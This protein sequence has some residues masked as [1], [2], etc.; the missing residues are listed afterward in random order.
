V[1]LKRLEDALAEG[2][3]V[4]AVVRGSAVNNDG[5]RKVGYTAPGLDG[6]AQVIAEA[7]AHAGVDAESIGYIEA[8]GTATPL[9]DAVELAAMAQA[10][11]RSTQ[12][13]QFCAL[14][15]VKP[16]VGHLDRAAGVAGLIKTALALWH[17]Q[18]PP[19]LNFER[20]SA[21]VE[22]ENSPFYVNTRLRDWDAG[23]GPR[24]AGV[25]SFGLGGTNAHVVL[26]EAPE[27]APSDPARGAQ[28]LVLSAKTAT[29]LESMGR[30]LARHLRAHGEL[31]VADVAYT[32]QVG[33]SAFNH[34]RMLVCADL[35]DAIAGLEQGRGVTVE[36]TSRDRA[37][38]LRFAAEARGGLGAE[39]I[40]AELS[41]GAALAAGLSG[42]HA[43]ARWLVE[44]GVLVAALDGAGV[45]ARMRQD[46]AL[47]RSEPALWIEVSA[48]ELTAAG[49]MEVVG[50]LWLGGVTVG[51]EELWKGARRRRVVLPT[52]PFERRRY[53][54]EAAPSVAAAEVAPAAA[55]SGRKAE[56][57]DWFYVPD[58]SPVSASPVAGAGGAAAGSWIVVE[59]AGGTGAGVAAHLAAAGHRVRRI[60][61]GEA[62]DIGALAAGGEL[63]SGIVHLRSLDA[64]EIAGGAD[65]FER[66]RELGFADV[67]ALAADLSR[68]VAD[69]RIDFV[70]ASRAVQAVLPGEAGDAE[71]APLIGLCK[72]I[73]Q[74]NVTVTCRSVD[75]VSVGAAAAAEIAQECLGAGRDAVVS[76]RGGQRYVQAYAPRRLAAP[77]G[78]V[79]RERGVYLITGGL[80]G[81]GLVLAEHMARQVRA[82]LVLLGRTAPGAAQRAK[83]S[84]LE[85]LGA[86][87]LVVTADV[88]DAA[89]VAAAVAQAQARFGGLDGVVHAAG[90]TRGEGF[91][92]L[93]DVS[94]AQCDLHFGPK[95]LGLYSLEQALADA[96]LDFC[97]VFS[98][99]ASVLGGLGFAA[100]AAANSFMDAFVQRHNRLEGRA[101]WTSVNWDTWRLSASDGDGLG[102]TVAQ[103]EMRPEEGIAAFERV[104]GCGETQIVNSTGDLD[105]RIRQ[106]VALESV[107]SGE[108]AAVAS[109]SEGLDYA[110]RIAGVW[111][112]V[113]GV[114]QVGLHDNFF[115]LGGNS[116][117]GLQ[118]IARLKKEFKRQIPAVALFE[119][120]TVSALAGYLRPEGERGEDREIG[121]LAQR[122]RQAAG[123]GGE[124][125]II[126]MV[127]RFPGADDVEELWGNLR[128]GVESLTRFSDEELLASGIDAGLIQDPH[129][130]KARPILRDVE[131][132][133][134]GLFGY[135]PR[136]AEL[137][138]PQQRLFQECAWEVL[139]KAGY[140]PQRYAGLIGVFG[141]TNL[142]TYLLRLAGDPQVQDLISETTVLEND[143]D[144]LTLNVSYRL[145]LRGPSVAVQTFCSTSLVAVHMACRA[146]RAGDC[147]L[148]LA[149]GVSVRV[150]VKAGYLYQEG[151]Q[152]SHDGHCRTFDSAADGTMFGDGVALVVLKRLRE[153]IE[154]GD[155]VH[156]VIKGSAVNNDG[157]LK[158]GY[159]APSVVGQAA[160]VEAALA[161]AGVT[162][163]SI[164][165]VEAHGTATRLGDP[166][167]V[168]ALSKAFR[169]TTQKRNYCALGSIKPNV[170]HLDRAAGVSG[171]IKTVLSL[172]H[173]ELP[174]TLHFAHPNPEI[175]FAAS[176][177]FVVRERRAWRAGS[178]PRRACVNSLGVGGT[179]A[180]VV[181]EEAPARGPSG[182]SRGWHLLVL[183]GRSAAALERVSERLRAHLEKTPELSLA[184]AAHTLQVGRRVLEHRRML[185]C[186]D[187][188]EAVELLGGGQARR[189]WTRAQKPANRSVAM[190]FA[191]VGEQYAGCGRELYE[192]EAC[193]RSAV[194]RCCRVLQ[195]HLGRDLREVMLA[196]GSGAGGGLGALIGRGV[197]VEAPL[198]ETALSQPAAFVLDYA[199]AQLW[200]SW[201]VQPAAVLGYSV[202]EYVAACV[203]GVFS[204]EDALALVARRAQAIDKLAG[205]AMLAVSLDEAQVQGWVDRDIAL[206]AVNSP[207]ACV[208]AG[209]AEAI[210]RLQRRLEAADVACH[211]VETT[212]A[213]HTPLL[214]PAAAELTALAATLARQAP[215]IPCLSNVTGDWMT[216]AQAGDP[217]YWAEHMCQPVRFADAVDKLLQQ[218]NQLLLEVGPAASLA[219]F[220]RQHPGCSRERMTEI[221]ST[222]APPHE[223]Q[224]ELQAML[225][226]LGK[227]WLLDLKPDWN[228]F[229]QDQKR[230]KIQLPTY[231]FERQHFW[232]KQKP[233]EAKSAIAPPRPEGRKPDP[234]DWFYRPVWQPSVAPPSNAAMQPG[235]FV[236][237]ADAGSFGDWI[238]ERLEARARVFR[239]RSG[240]AFERTDERSFQ[241]R[242]GERS[243]YAQLVRLLAAAQQ[244]MPSCIHL[245]SVDETNRSFAE[246]QERAV[247]S[248]LW[249][250][251]ALGEHN[252]DSTS[253]V[254]IVT[255][256]AQP[257]DGESLNVSAAPIVAACTVLRQEY[258]GLRC[259][260]VDICMREPGGGG[261]LVDTLADELLRD[262]NE[263]HIAFRG[264]ARLAPRFD[265]LRLEAPDQDI[266]ARLRRHGVYLILGGLGGIGLN[267]AK[268]LAR[269]VQ[270]RLI[271]VSRSGR[272]VIPQIL[273]E[274]ESLGAE[275]LVHRADIAELEQLQQ[276]VNAA[277][278][279][280]GAIDGV[281]HAAGNVNS[282][283]FI[284]VQ[285]MDR[286]HC[287]V[288]FGAKVY[289]LYNLETVLGERPLDFCLLFS[290]ISSVLGGIGYLGYTAA[291]SFMDAF[292]QRHNRLGGRA[293][294][295]SVNWDT[296]R[297]SASD[298]DGLGATVAQYEMR[299]EEGIAAFERVL[300][301]GETQIVNSTGDLDA[302]IRQWV[303]LESVRS[304]EQ[305]AVASGSEGLDYAER[306]AGVWRHVLGV[307][308]VGLHDNFFDLGGN[309]LIGLQLIARLKKEF[310]RQIP[311]VALFE[312]PTVSALAGY[313]RPEGE[314][315]EDREIGRLAQ[316]RRQAAGT[317]GEIAIIAMV[318]RF[319]GADDVEELWGNL[320]DGVESLT[321]FSDEELLASGI[322]AGLIQDPHYVKARPILRDVEH[323]D[324]GLFGYTPREAELMDPQQRLFQ[325]CAWEVLEK[326]GYDPQRY[327]GLI[328]V[329]G[330]TNLN[331]YLLRLAGDP[332][333]QDLISETTV[334]EN[335]KDALTLNVSYRLNLRGPSV[336]VQTFCSTSLVAVHM[337]CRALRAGDCD[338]ALAGGVSV[339]VP[340]KA[341]YL[342]QEGDQVSH[343]GHC[344][345]FDSAADGTMFG[346]GV[347]LVVLKR[348]REAIEDGDE[349][350][351][352][353]KG[354][355][356]NNDGGLKVGYTAPSVV[357]QAAVVEAALADA[358]VTAES[359]DYVEAHGTAT[360]LGDPIEV[361]ALSKA[362]RSTTQKRNYCALGSIKPNVGH[363]DRA[364]GVSGLIKTVLSL[365]HEELPATLHFAHPNPE[366]DFAASPFFV[367]RERRAWRAG[368]RPRRACVNSLGVGG[369]NAHVVVEEAP[370]RGPSGPSRGWHLLVLSGRSAAALERVSERLRAH[371]EKTPELSLADAA[372][373]LQVGRRVL[374][375]RRMLVCRDVGE[376]VELLGGGQAR[377]VWT[378]AQKPANRSVAMVFAG[379]GEQYAGCGRELYESE[380]CFRSAVDRCCR[381]LQQ[382]LGRD[383]REVM[384][385]P[386]SGA[387]GGLGA[388]IGRGVRVEAPL[389]E[390]ALSQPAA[391]VLDYA[392]AQ[393]WMSWGVQPAA[394]LGYSVGE[395]VAACVA[396]VF[397]LED[398]LALVA[399]RAQA[400]DKLAGGAMLAVSLDE[401]QVQGWVDRD[402]ALAAVNSPAACVLA[403]SAEAI[404]RLQRRLEA[405]DVACH[406][407]ETTHA[408]H[409]PLLRPA[410]AELTALAA[411]LARQAPKIP[412]LSN[413]TGDWMTAAQAGDPAY[414]AEHMCQPVRF[415]D[416]VDKLLQ[417]PNQL[418]LEVGP[419]ASLAS[420]MRQHPG[421]SRERM[422]EILSTF[423]PPHE[424]QTELQAML[425][426]LGKLWLL[427]LKPDWNAFS[428]DQKRR[429]IQ[430]PTYPFERQ[431]FWINPH[432]SYVATAA[433]SR[434]PDISDWFAIPSWK[435]GASVPLAEPAAEQCWL[436]LIDDSGVG[437]QLAQWLQA[438]RQHVVTLIPASAY[439]R[440]KPDIY[441]V[442]P[443]V[444]ADYDAVL[445][446]LEMANSLPSRVV[447]LWMV[448]EGYEEAT[449]EVLERGF[450]S[451]L[452]L[453][454]ALGDR[455][456]DSCHL[457]VVSSG[458]QEVVGSEILSPAKAAT[459]GPV[460]VIPQEY[461]NLSSRSIDIGLPV[462]VDRLAAEVLAPN[463]DEFVA[464]RGTFRWVQYF[465]P[466]KLGRSDEMRIR[467]R[468]V[469]LISG[470]LGGI[471]M[472]LAEK[473]A[474]HN[475]RLV[476]VGRKARRVPA[477]E[478]LEALGAEVLVQQADVG[479]PRQIEGAVQAALAHFGRIDGVLHTAGVPGIG[480]MQLKTAEAAAAVLRPKVQG[481]MALAQALEGQQLDFFVLFSSVTSATGGGPGQADYCAA[482]AFLDAWARRHVDKFPRVVSIS[483]GEW[484]WD[485]WQEGLKGFPETIRRFF[486]ANR[487]YY[488]L[489]FEEGTEALLRILASDLPH[490]F[491]TTQDL[492]SMVAR[493]RASSAASGLARLEDQRRAQR[494]HPRPDLA[495][496]FVAPAGELE[497]RIASL[498]GQS[499]GIEPIG[500]D[501]NFFDLGGNSL[502]G[503]DIVAKLRKQIGLHRLPAYVL[504]EAPT[505]R[506]LARYIDGRSDEPA[507]TVE[508]LDAAT[509]KRSEQLEYF[510]LR[511]EE[512]EL[513]ANL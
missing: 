75:V 147:D 444:K 221:L 158:V 161:D 105:A 4:Y 29:A 470:G 9:G 60:G 117:I 32:L 21:E 326:A 98:S 269:T 170:G 192:S 87:I 135:T 411:T 258:L 103:Y 313:L 298:G 445:D 311:A 327:A 190:V 123:T 496:S 224:T 38:G 184:D 278:A 407:V 276:A 441:E 210:A 288:H 400:I 146:L 74:E 270:G 149:G 426:T 174:A 207:A 171:L 391:F 351:A 492:P 156:A 275:V 292:V 14:G 462:H 308:Q 428:Q 229:S 504:Y 64:P 233:R 34:R 287:E 457:D 102:A 240:T 187:V 83:L 206:A 91:A 211:P 340:V 120:P 223:R 439:T 180:H 94:V 454:K 216:A 144:A 405:A 56:I 215:K 379:V 364:A 151:D 333:V 114:E 280:F 481:T 246:Y 172:Q 434:R 250:A 3:H 104:L 485:A 93:Q 466:H 502:L 375:H 11:G 413:V 165:Y 44:R 58:W 455:G 437:T 447:H 259:R 369:T 453:T 406:P 163:E 394:V 279:R 350:H 380:A 136:E 315:G 49:L 65:R 360:R 214:R 263:P 112:H 491:V 365:Q 118:L 130:V 52:Y 421:C 82:R 137:M 262:A 101:R 28:L 300:G 404:A 18:L 220:M 339:R 479:E 488:G 507:D 306:I 363:L 243:D 265:R 148:A 77:S 332:Q 294:W 415:A 450:Y 81:I 166:I 6:Q 352:V 272:P 154:D 89:G 465:E 374:E 69:E 512:A 39:L 431:H 432:P 435:R 343:D 183:S 436:V 282:N 119:A 186:R 344:R 5:I 475:A 188:G 213:F 227:L 430:L 285:N 194:D 126:A 78:S 242:I 92:P 358:G 257:F 33:R 456:V 388:L 178:R 124:I 26:E 319:P 218:P 399:R 425:T 310:K 402:I 303:A 420:F 140:D 423:A 97:V 115:D 408:F 389:R 59:D 255:D 473:F 476:L 141:G 461:P 356:V 176:P 169:S 390:T 321:R 204:L 143:K 31:N 48:G 490:V 324:A 106:W 27:L 10:F 338:L 35:E 359:I 201:G 217:A 513:G 127:G 510:R 500:A 293:R 416:A 173:E 277:Q 433:T 96:A 372:H 71:Q 331:T 384:L 361:A 341:G 337:A 193:F 199:L 474:K 225:T 168:A 25:S 486:I 290:S 125:A 438:H 72:V 393:L 142:N 291:N 182:P 61:A 134:A 181:V 63:P 131:H 440:R 261:D 370:A 110:E 205:G 334:L 85:G 362:F 1:V 268:Y 167:E 252:L 318:G 222:F 55:S 196:P 226:T 373:T 289:G 232:I 95:V 47:S 295:T 128:D 309:S 498:W 459:I 67:L 177:F 256:S 54:L 109:G 133:D 57:A 314:R 414:W 244:A 424:R 412:C 357:G 129:Y 138:D 464:L 460:K 30:Q 122:R 448:G 353:I 234:A 366:I 37:V 197:R 495:S 175:D 228:A 429:K 346:D 68:H 12:K 100:Y 395:Y 443:T 17:K 36:Q 509:Q 378:R 336:A 348:L 145:N 297:L 15:S 328:G 403:G 371:L 503:I 99:L 392:L 301:C 446:D 386:G 241:I 230:R 342:Y 16:N 410:A 322:D 449:D 209:S 195:Q 419:A 320:R 189:V 254:T 139:E 40:E 418:L 451:L 62:V 355:A 253:A 86:E 482:N 212:H 198:R 497:E 80:G 397:S 506:A 236:I 108:Q 417:Q 164:D 43:I 329:F 155:E 88:A 76:Y 471:A 203:A 248:L 24:R 150:P 387:G 317:G 508:P 307:E 116:L 22:L 121:R 249:L 266:P 13:K 53:W 238:A 251:Q 422:T 286:N 483:W 162:A 2:D 325:E 442:R 45:D 349:V 231:P 505:V 316:R 235:S 185:V 458:L 396:G 463:V 20:A 245:W 111:R 132:F 73:G 70:V 84:E 247:Y 467:E 208:L 153:A 368:S 367:V 302:R 347:A 304:G 219:S 305:A 312:A 159:T 381:V 472:G 477:V 283:W 493:S 484:Q 273:I 7:L 179:N 398:A 409:T 427:D 113:L 66:C 157:G 202:G 468:G 8:H 46:L 42:S 264:G 160:V 478:R 260:S 452:A 376:A 401:A 271:L 237:F 323:F 345:T 489:T 330:G 299:P 79:L 239:V 284:P 383:L 191:G 487:R 200:M 480:L 377:R 385:A 501:D 296:W 511:R 50:R 382:H 274:L 152:V 51:W 107:R 267:I 41:L 19:S 499:L 281:I 354:S 469:Y 23:S 494:R 90:M 335:D